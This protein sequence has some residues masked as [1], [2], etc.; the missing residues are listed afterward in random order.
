MQSI[1]EIQLI[2]ED[3]NE[4]FTIAQNKSGKTAQA[5]VSNRLADVRRMLE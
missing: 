1:A 4:L 2:N 5:I 3:N